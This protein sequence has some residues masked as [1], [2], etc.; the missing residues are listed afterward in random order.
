MEQ[1]GEQKKG[2]RRSIRTSAMVK[3]INVDGAN[4]TLVGAWLWFEIVLSGSSLL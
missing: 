4:K 3:E 2:Q 1:P